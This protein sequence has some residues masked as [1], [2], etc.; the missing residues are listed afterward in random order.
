MG[1]IC[2]DNYASTYAA[3]NVKQAL[4]RLIDVLQ[5]PEQVRRLMIGP[6]PLRKPH[7]KLNTKPTKP[8]LETPAKTPMW[9]E[10]SASIAKH[11]HNVDSEKATTSPPSNNPSD[12]RKTSSGGSRPS[13]CS[14]SSSYISI[15]QYH[16]VTK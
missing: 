14:D 7:T 6:G 16:Q 12:K 5:S 10:T 2:K 4:D 9:M 8:T 13:R 1:R 15:D 11:A 3:K